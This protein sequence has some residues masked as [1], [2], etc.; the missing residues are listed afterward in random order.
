MT[1]KPPE[2]TPSSDRSLLRR[3]RAGEQDAATDLFLKY[4][5]RLQAL[6]RAKTSQALAARFDPE[7]VIQSVFR[8]FFRRASS[9]LY[10]VPE[11]DELW[12][13]L[14]VIALNKIRDLAAHHRAQKRDVARTDGQLEERSAD[15]ESLATLEVVLHDFLGNLP[16]VQ[17]EVAQMR[18]EGYQVDEIAQRTGRSKRTVERTL[19]ALRKNLLDRLDTD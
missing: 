14:L 11:G 15:Q 12:Q 16:Q 1:A 5:A 13:L 4:G 6:A 9:G 8:T 10:D 3:L 19:N 2:E 7:D 18:M 17:S